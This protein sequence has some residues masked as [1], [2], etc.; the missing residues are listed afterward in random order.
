M[1]ATTITYILGILAVLIGAAKF[2][3]FNNNKNNVVNNLI[4]RINVKPT[5]GYLDDN[6]DICYIDGCIMYNLTKQTYTSSKRTVSSLELSPF[7]A[8]RLRFNAIKIRNGLI[9]ELR[10]KGVDTD[11]VEV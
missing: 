3:G 10:V 6:L 8:I 1:E 2:F 7:H 4:Y 5:E 11:Q 9:A